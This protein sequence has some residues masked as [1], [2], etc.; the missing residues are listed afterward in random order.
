MTLRLTARPPSPARWIARWFLALAI[1]LVP[2]ADAA[3]AVPF[4]PNSAWN[5]PLA[6]TAP[7]AS[8]SAAL[9]ADLNRQVTAYTTSINTTKYSVPV[10]AVPAGQPTVKVTLDTTAPALAADFAAVPL[11][12]D[13][14]P[15]AG[16]DQHLTV[17]QPSTDSLWEFW[18]MAKK[19]DGW[20]ARWGGKMTNVSANPGYFA[21]PYGATATSLPLIGGLMRRDELSASKIDH[22]LAISVWDVRKDVV[23][24]PAQRTDGTTTTSASIP[25]GT[26]FRFPASLNLDA[27]SMPAAT[28]AMA[29]AVQRYG[30]IVRDRAYCV[31]FYAED[32]TQWG[33]SPYGSIFGTPWLDGN[34]ALRGFPWSKLQAVVAERSAAVSPAFA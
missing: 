18:L 13:A 16:S 27:I 31:C 28:R 17:W 20:H 3:A 29:K 22:A 21:N 9:V 19:A 23:R 4:A 2:A 30:M 6:D 34:N 32:T 7:L 26:R 5:A 25:E 33:A 1:C 24:W 10:Y 11:P 15:A 8:D 12:A 14:R